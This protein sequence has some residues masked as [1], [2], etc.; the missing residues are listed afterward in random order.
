M[1]EL[2]CLPALEAAGVEGES[3]TQG[4]SLTWICR[5]PSA[6]PASIPAVQELS[7]EWALWGSGEGRAA[8]RTQPQGCSC[9]RA[10]GHTWGQLTPK[11]AQGDEQGATQP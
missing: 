7:P 1:G 5:G 8:H 6:A 11:G 4:H 10:R 9:S 3:P 2:F